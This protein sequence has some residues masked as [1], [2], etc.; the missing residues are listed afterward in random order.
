MY[1]YTYIQAA[2]GSRITKRNKVCL[3]T[4]AGERR[5][6]GRRN[7]RRRAAIRERRRRAE[8]HAHAVARAHA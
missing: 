1:K 5:E 6:N 7:G 4:I 3:L 2:A 8:H